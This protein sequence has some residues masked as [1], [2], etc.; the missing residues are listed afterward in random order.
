MPLGV[1]QSV[2]ISALLFAI[3]H[4]NSFLVGRDPLFV[5]AQIVASFLGGIGLAALWIRLRTIVPLIVLHAVND[6][7]QF[8]AT[9]GLEAQGVRF[10][11]LC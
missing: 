8:S 4:A 3:I 5:M 11:S 9:G 1:M 2:L 10:T 7:L 6:F